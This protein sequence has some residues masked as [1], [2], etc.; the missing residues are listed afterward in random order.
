MDKFLKKKRDFAECDPECEQNLTVGSCTSKKAKP[1][2]TRKYDESYLS[3]GFTFTGSKDNPLPLCLV[4]GCKMSNESL[5]PSKLSKHFQTKHSHL[6]GKSA[7]YFKRM[8]EQQT[9]AASSFKNVMTFSE[10][11]QIASYE[12]SELIAKNM[13]AHTLGESI[14]LPACKKI[15]ETMLG[16]EAAMKISKV[17]LSNNTVHRRIVEMSSDIERNVCSNKLQYSNFALQIDESTD[18][19]N[20]AQ[21]LAFIRFI[22]DDQIVNQFLFCKKLCLT[23]KGEDVFNI[24][25]N[26]FDK[27][28]LSWKSCVGICTDGAPSMV[29]CVKGLTSFVKKQ[30][31]NIIVT[32]CFLH[33]EALMAK[34][35]GDKLREVLDQVVQMVNFIKIRPVKS[36]LFEQICV[37]MDSQHRRLLLHTEVRWLSRGKVLA[38]VHELRQELLAFF[39]EMKQIH[40]CDLLRCNFWIDGLK[41]LTDIFQQLNN[42]NTNMQGKEENILT[43]TDKMKA[44][45]KKLQIW[46]RK[47]TEGNLEMFPLVSKTC[48]DKKSKTL[49]LIVEHLTTLEEKLSSY[50]PSL[51]TEQYDWIRNPFIENSSGFDLTLIEEEELAAISTDRGLMIKHKE[52]PLD[53]FWIS[54]KEEYVSISKKAL[55]ILLQFSTSYLCEL[56]FSTLTSIKCKKRGSLLDIDEEMRVCLSSIRPNIKEIAKT[57]QAH[58]SHEHVNE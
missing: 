41:Y 1:R 17:P 39:E 54:I 44:F 42:L 5:L 52:L 47:A 10:K 28:Q 19:T 27:W 36:R 33:R 15:V 25:N 29:G 23:T 18:I 53:T 51:N 21:L 38:R 31:E 3:F 34:T 13:K 43:S 37:D 35:L 20:Q 6:Q 48:I 4:C 32:H 14:I 22:D 16:N 40:F 49:P 2:P 8:L 7:S 9:E 45:Q 11:A 55:N 12:V 46:K 24:L 30:N 58:V 50:F 56:G 57:H 26:Y